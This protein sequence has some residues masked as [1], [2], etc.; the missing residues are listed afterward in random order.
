LIND[1]VKH[2]DGIALNCFG[3]ESDEGRRLFSEVRKTCSPHA[4][5]AFVAHRAEQEI[6]INLQR[7]ARP[8]TVMYYYHNG[9][10]NRGNEDVTNDDDVV[11]ARRVFGTSLFKEKLL[12]LG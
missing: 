11:S 10:A 12:L 3:R 7:D 5:E 8:K 4:I 2:D 6:V 1:H 9:R